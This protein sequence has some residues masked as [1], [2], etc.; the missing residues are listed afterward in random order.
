MRATTVIR[1]VL[2]VSTWHCLAAFA[3]GQ[4]KAQSSELNKMSSY[5]Q[6]WLDED[7]L[8]II[9][10]AERDV[11]TKLTT[12]EE[13]DGFIEFFW[14]RR[15]PDPATVENEFKVEHYRRIVY[16]NENFSA[17]IQG[18]KSDRGMTYIK[19]GPP[20]RRE[21]NPGGGPYARE[22][23]EG[24]GMTSVFPFER[25]E[26]RNIEGVGDNIE[27]EFV[28][29]RGGGL[30]ELT[31]DKQRKDALLLSGMMGLTD[32]ELEV[33]QMTGSTSKQDR[34][35]GRRYSG[36]GAGTTANA[37]AF[38]SVRDK[39]FEQLLLSSRLNRAPDIKFKDL[40]T[41]VSTRISYNL[42]PFDTRLD[43]VRLT[44]QQVMVPVTI[45]LANQHLTFRE[46]YGLY[47]ATAQIYGRVVDLGNRIVA[48]FEDEVGRDFTAETLPQAKQRFSAYQKRLILKPGLYKLDVGVKDVAS[49]RIGIVERRIEVPNLGDGELKLS[50]LILA[51]SIESGSQDRSA[52][53]FI[54]G[55]LKVIPK[56]DE[57]FRSPGAVGVYV[58]IYNFAL[59]QQTLKPALK[60]EY[61]IA[62]KGAQPETWRDISSAVQFAGQ[63]CRLARM[64]TLGRRQPGE[65]TLH[66][67]VRDNISN[68]SAASA[69]SFTVVN[70]SP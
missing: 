15:D 2:I 70:E 28:D 10:E 46:S 31:W 14:A 63:Y 53:S 17:G 1:T 61:G 24:G 20:D 19:F 26:Y 37:S 65:Y 33:L 29:D 6:K 9:T 5:Y 22:R 43:F 44:D 52:S 62:P 4:S 64:I 41:A 68:K 23:K 35:A 8:W 11:F 30:Y 25:W 60:F 54:L 38:E 27:L 51:D 40:E 57:V 45:R 7:V 21:T 47:H 59:D 42:V 18:W 58:Q 13:R 69:A 48:V 3:I 39:P 66:V 67:R 49:N 55:D 16:A 36:E 34:V 50:S 32:D 56:T 12:D